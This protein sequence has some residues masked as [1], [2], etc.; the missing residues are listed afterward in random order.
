MKTIIIL[1]WDDT[2]FPTTEYL[3]MR[4]IVNFNELDNILSRLINLIHKYGDVYIVTNAMKLWVYN[5]LKY[6]PSLKK[7]IDNNISIISARDLY[8]HKGEQTIM[9]WKPMVFKDITK[10]SGNNIIIIGDS[11]YEET[12]IIELK[13]SLRNRAYLKLVRFIPSPNYH[14]IKEQLRLLQ[15]LFKKSKIVNLSKDID[16]KFIIK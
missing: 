2:L 11:V 16:I 4:Y 13:K 9:S 7:E 3:A 8:E 6:M 5:L 1:D 12:G 14:I 15:V 10:D